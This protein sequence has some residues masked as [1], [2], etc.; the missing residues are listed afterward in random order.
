MRRFV[1]IDL[2][3]TGVDPWK[4][5]IIEVGLA[6]EGLEGNYFEET[7]SLPFDEKA[8]SEG[9]AAVNGWGKREFPPRREPMNAAGYLA[10][11]LRDAHLVGKNPQF[12]EMFLSMFFRY[13]GVEKTWHYRLVDV[14]SMAWAWHNRGELIY[15]EDPSANDA[16][17]LPQP[18]NV[19]TVEKVLLIPRQREG[20]Y[21]TA[22]EDAKWAYRA[23]RHMVPNE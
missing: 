20:G 13:F 4:D 16:Y 10:E 7:F 1:A 19:E 14:G 6:G 17:I 23:F 9:A 12:D 8:M 18:P 22:L 21:H 11:V 5:Y 15:E 2:E 3:T